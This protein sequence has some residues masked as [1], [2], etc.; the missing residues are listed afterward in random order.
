MLF[1]LKLKKTHRQALQPPCSLLKLTQPNSHYTCP[2]S[3]SWVTDNH[4]P[5]LLSEKNI[6]N[7]H[8]FNNWSPFIIKVKIHNTSLKAIK[9]QLGQM[10]LSSIVQTLGTIFIFAKLT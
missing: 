9:N 5:L 6:D 10:M 3:S 8:Q 7:I 4:C 2:G 1:T